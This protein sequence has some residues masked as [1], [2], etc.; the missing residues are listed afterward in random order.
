MQRL[1]TPIVKGFYCFRYEERLRDLDIFSKSRRHTMCQTAS[2]FLCT[3]GFG[4]SRL[5]CLLHSQVGF[6][7][8]RVFRLCLARSMESTCCF[9]HLSKAFDMA[10]LRLLLTRLVAQSIGH[11]QR[12][13]VAVFLDHQHMR[14][15]VD[16]AFSRPVFITNGYLQVPYSF[17]YS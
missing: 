11:T 6:S 10:N 17:E 14:I 9:L 13:L 15:W 5:H 2:T 4:D 12:S 16:D 1:V 7:L 8:N 3:T